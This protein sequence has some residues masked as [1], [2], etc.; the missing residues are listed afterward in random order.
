M[1]TARVTNPLVS[2]LRPTSTVSEAK[3]RL[4]QSLAI[5]KL[6]NHTAS[7]RW[8][9]LETS[10]ATKSLK[11][12]SII[13]SNFKFKIN[14]QNYHYFL[15]GHGGHLIVEVDSNICLLQSN[16]GVLLPRSSWQLLSEESSSFTSIGFMPLH[17]ITAARTLAPPAWT[18]P[19]NQ[20]SPLG[21]LLKKPAQGDQ[22]CA[23]LIKSALSMIVAL[24]E[25]TRE[26]NELLDSVGLEQDLYNAMALIVF[27]DL[28]NFEF[29]WHRDEPDEVDR[30]LYSILDF[31]RF[32]LDREL[33]ISLL[34]AQANCSRRS[35]EYAFKK[36]IGCTPLQW[37]RRER[38]ALALAKLE[39]SDPTNSTVKDI[40]A[41]CGYKSLSRFYIDFRST[42]GCTPYDILRLTDEG[43]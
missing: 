33:P 36:Q 15:F 43:S 10:V 41:S 18:P 5:H 4:G 20:D 32:N 12:A 13:G 24:V 29:G 42:Y 23:E 35:L 31:I 28:R 3:R 27:D 26:D 21:S 19:L 39:T 38:M 30:R 2:L 1:K 9:M 34:Q 14:D 6:E 40:A 25:L 22:D 37:I 8:F 7:N 16:K 11:I 17:L